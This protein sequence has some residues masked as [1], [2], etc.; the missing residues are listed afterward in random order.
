MEN[1]DW[2]KAPVLALVLGFVI[3]LFREFKG[4]VD[5]RQEKRP[6]ALCLAGDHMRAH[7]ERER[8]AFEGITDNLRDIAGVLKS[9]QENLN[10]QEL[11]SREYRVEFRESLRRIEAKP[12]VVIER[13]TGIA[14][15]RLVEGE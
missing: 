12:P 10:R 5:K 15:A 2:S 7:E 6:A 11:D 14:A 9:T 4:F 1:L 8:E 3:L 13:R